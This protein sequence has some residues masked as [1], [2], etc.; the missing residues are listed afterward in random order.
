MNY[1]LKELEIDCMSGTH[2]DSQQRLACMAS[3]DHECD[4]KFVHNDKSYS[5]LFADLI[6]AV[7]QD[8]PP[9]G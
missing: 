8:T 2:I 6:N 4:V 9:R 3:I 7:V 1:R 5:V